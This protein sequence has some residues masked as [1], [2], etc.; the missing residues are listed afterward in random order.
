MTLIVCIPL[1]SH[2]AAGAVGC[3]VM[4]GLALTVMVTALLVTGAPQ[5]PVTITLYW[6]PFIA[7]VGL[8]RVSKLVV[9]PE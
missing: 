1:L 6:Y 7:N 3:T 9:P 4:P 2:T 5:P 8:V